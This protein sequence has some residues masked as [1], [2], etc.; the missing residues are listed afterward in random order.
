M[1]VT[2]VPAAL[3]LLLAAAWFV[4]SASTRHWPAFRRAHVS[5][6]HR[7]ITYPRRTAAR[8]LSL[9]MKLAGRHLTIG[10]GF[11]AAIF[12]RLTQ[13]IARPRSPPPT[14]V[15]AGFRIP[16][17][18]IT[19]TTGLT[20]ARSMRCGCSRAGTTPIREPKVSSA[21]RIAPMVR[22]IQARPRIRTP[23]V[24]TTAR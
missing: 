4:V 3:P 21:H 1:R 13:P 6:A 8:S 11:T 12:L 5:T 15:R 18:S 2:P 7:S 22:S 16:S 19:R 23:S 10:C 20:F 24:P 17:S 9:D 14:Q